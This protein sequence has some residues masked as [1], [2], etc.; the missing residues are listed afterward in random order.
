MPAEMPANNTPAMGVTL[1]GVAKQFVREKV[2]SGVDH[3]FAPGSRTALLGPNG[4][5]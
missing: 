4:S 3:V 1:K 2:F 5:G